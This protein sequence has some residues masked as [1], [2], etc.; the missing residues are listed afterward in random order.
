MQLLFIFNTCLVSTLSMAV[1]IVL[2]NSRNHQA[3]SKQTGRDGDARAVSLF[4]CFY[5]CIYLEMMT[6]I[7][8]L[9]CVFFHFTFS[10]SLRLTKHRIKASL[11]RE[12]ERQEGRRAQE[13]R[14]RTGKPVPARRAYFMC[15]LLPIKT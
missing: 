10:S 9:R 3:K 12:I 2:G 15:L 7:V 8:R 5:L 1:K 6:L 11:S 4:P 14:E 13:E